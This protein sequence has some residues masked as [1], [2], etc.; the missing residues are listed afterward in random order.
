MKNRFHIAHIIPS[1]KLHIFHGYAEVI[2]TITWGLRDLGREVTHSVNKIRSDATNIVFGAQMLELAALEAL[3]RDTIIYQLEQMAGGSAESIR[4]SLKYCAAQFAIWDYSE[5]NLPVWR[6]LN[7]D[8]RTICV[9]IGYAPI[10]SRIPKP[11][12]QDIDVL[13]YGGPGRHGGRLRVIYDLCQNLVKTV[14]VHG[15]YGAS[16]DGLI[17]RSKIVLNLNQ[18]PAHNIFEIARVSYLLANR[19]AV[20]SDFSE[21]ARIES[22]LTS[23]LRFVPAEQVVSECLRMLDNDA[24]RCALEQTGFE[25]FRKRDIR[26]SL[27][28]AM[29]TP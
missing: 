26:R 13:F 14:F 17:A 21:R 9:P 3:P 10:L 20:V 16:R 12:V 18:R 28:A 2:E 7:P 5:F 23:A 22:D 8:V 24:E 1:P 25:I 19:K 27:A 4:D 15:L 6:N 29:A 11:E